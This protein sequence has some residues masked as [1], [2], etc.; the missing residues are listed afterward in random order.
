MAKRNSKNTKETVSKVSE[1]VAAPVVAI[2]AAQPP[3]VEP[4][5]IE[6]PVVEP[7]VV[8]PPVITSP[9]KKEEDED[10]VDA[11]T[12]RGLLK[13]FIQPYLDNY[14]NEKEFHITSDGQV[15]L[16]E[17][18]LDAKAHQKQLDSEKEVFVFEV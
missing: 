2:P 7:P 9:A 1:K 15:F 3:V 16:K 5:V 10:V 18:A 12:K 17:N 6:P 11:D 14:P 8:E 4:P 13:D